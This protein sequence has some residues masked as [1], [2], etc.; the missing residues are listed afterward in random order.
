MT[1]LDI[2]PNVVKPGW[3]PLIII[4][5]LAAVMVLLYRSMRHQFSKI[6]VPPAGGPDGSDPTAQ[7]VIGD[8][9][10]PESRGDVAADIGELRD[11]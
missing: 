3:T 11:R 4:L 7:G 2:D 9:T 1:I 10:E 8:E 6:S 5:V